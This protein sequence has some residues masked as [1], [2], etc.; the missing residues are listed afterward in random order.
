MMASDLK[1]GRAQQG[2]RCGRGEFKK[3][4]ETIGT[5]FWHFC[6]ENT[7]R[8]SY[9]FEST[10]HYQRSLHGYFVCARGLISRESIEHAN[11]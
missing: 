6:I 9:T 2:G 4:S 1:S 5:L 3:S 10:L 11:C 7:Y 8:H